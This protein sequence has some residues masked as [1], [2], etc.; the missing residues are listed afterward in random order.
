[1]MISCLLS[2]NYLYFFQIA[3]D[4]WNKQ[5]EEESIT[6][7]ESLEFEAFP[8]RSNIY[9]AQAINVIY[10]GSSPVT[11]M[12]QLGW[13][14]NETFSRHDIDL[15]GYLKLIRAGTPP[16]SD[17]FWQGKPQTMAFQLPGNLMERS[18]IRWWDA[19]LDK[20]TGKRIWLGAISYDDGLKFAHYSGIMTIL[21]RVKRDVDIERDM[22]AKQLDLG[23]TVYSGNILPL[24]S[25]ENYSRKADFFSDGGVLVIAPSVQAPVER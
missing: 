7:L 21:H 15:R 10:L 5:V 22:L 12:S 24:N 9:A 14:E 23:S 17:L 25:P 18:H 2:M 11:L 8:G 20:S 3:D 1:M 16:V 4:N 6:T 13:L 19:G